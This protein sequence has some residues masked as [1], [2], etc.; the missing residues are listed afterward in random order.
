MIE[1]KWFPNEAPSDVNKLLDGWTYPG[2]KMTRIACQKK[3]VSAIRNRPS[4][5]TS[6]ATYRW[7][8]LIGSRTVDWALKRQRNQILLTY[9]WFCLFWNGI[10]LHIV[11]G[12]QGSVASGWGSVGRAVTSDT[13]DPQIKSWDRQNFTNQ[14]SKRKYKNKEKEGVNGPSQKK[15][16]SCSF[17]LRATKAV[18]T[19][20]TAQYKWL[21]L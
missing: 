3:I 7:W 10:S 11:G 14:L 13:K 15:Y 4:S 20:K 5:G 12:R 21:Y 8:S 1:S 6:G 9:R 17:V 18:N 2:W 19:S 16:G